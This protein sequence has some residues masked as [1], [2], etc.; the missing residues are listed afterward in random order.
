MTRERDLFGP[1]KSKLRPKAQVLAWR[2]QRQEAQRKADEQRQE[3]LKAEREE[4]F[5]WNI[6]KD[7]EVD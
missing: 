4:R 7:V 1:A 3:R 5:C 6:P 2:K